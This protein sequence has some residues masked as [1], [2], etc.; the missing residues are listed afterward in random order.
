M[1]LGVDRDLGC[2]AGSRRSRRGLVS[3]ETGVGSVL[4]FPDASCEHWRT[5]LTQMPQ[6]ELDRGVPVDGDA[7]LWIGQ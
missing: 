5:V 1:D 2:R 4:M 3:P 7:V 6:G